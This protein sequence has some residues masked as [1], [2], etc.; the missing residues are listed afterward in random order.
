MAIRAELIRRIRYEAICFL[1]GGRN[2][3][4]R[5]R[6]AES[7]Q[8]ASWRCE[9]SRR[10]RSRHHHAAHPDIAHDLAR[11]PRLINSGRFQRQHPALHDFL[12]Q[13]GDFAQ[14]F[15]ENPS[16]YILP[17][18]SHA[19]PR[20]DKHA[21]SRTENA[22]TSANASAGTNS[23]G[24]NAGAGASANTPASSGGE[25]PKGVPAASGGAGE[26]NSSGGNM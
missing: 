20:S 15:S 13:N 11:N 22:N 4:R 8:G 12:S 10:G 18:R 19:H 6:R 5:V 2:A 3:C 26:G 21:S 17:A 24:A 1:C 7:R 9:W 23:G 16:D 25:A 14:D